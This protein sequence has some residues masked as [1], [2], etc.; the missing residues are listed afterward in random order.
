MEFVEGRSKLAWSNVGGAEL[1]D[2]DAGS[3]V[4]QKGGIRKKR[5]CGHGQRQNAQNRVTR[6]RHVEHLAAGG[7]PFDTR[8]PDSLVGHLETCRGNVPAVW[9]GFFE[10]AHA[11]LAA[12]DDHGSAAKMGKQGAARLLD[13]FFV[14]EGARYVKSGFFGVADNHPGTTIRIK[15]C[16]L[17]LHEDGY[18]ELM[19]G[20]QNAVCKRVADQTLVI[21]GQNQR[22]H[23][24][25][26]S[27]KRAEQGFFGF[28]RQRFTALMINTNNLLVA[29]DYPCLDGRN[30]ARNGEHAT[31]SDLCLSEAGPQRCA[32]CIVSGFF[33]RAPL[34]PDD[35]EEHHMGAK[36]GQIGGYVSRTA[37]TIGL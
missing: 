36:R 18:L 33:S 5:S 19:T 15:P 6:S 14:L 25:Q 2:D 34:T 35:A 24:L 31:I 17:R 21:V 9:R 4:G 22:V 13:R 23:P 26:R 7:A 30:T 11:F 27:Q 20:V 12:R 1:T 28:G 16:R 3:G 29:R 32:G 10:D 37:Q 8:L